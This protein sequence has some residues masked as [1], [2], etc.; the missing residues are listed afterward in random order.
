[1]IPN[2]SKMLVAAIIISLL[3]GGVAGYFIGDGLAPKSDYMECIKTVRSGKGGANIKDCDSFA[4]ETTVKGMLENYK[5]CYET[6]KI[7]DKSEKLNCD[8][9]ILERFNKS[10]D[11]EDEE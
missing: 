9:E 6:Y 3:G 1:M 10:K 8:K 4:R 11:K 2:G 7:T 5:L